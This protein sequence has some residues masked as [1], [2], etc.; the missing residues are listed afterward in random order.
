[1]GNVGSN[2]VKA[3]QEEQKCSF[4]TGLNSDQIRHSRLSENVILSRARCQDNFLV[5][6]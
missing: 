4:D 3:S 2:E 1:M 5:G 6:V